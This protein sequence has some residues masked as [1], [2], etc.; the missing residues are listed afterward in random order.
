MKYLVM[1]PDYSPFLTNW[2]DYQNHYIEKMVIYNLINQT[3]S[4]DG[5]TWLEL[6]ID[7][8]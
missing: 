1:H 7:N 3:Y 5:I 8:L 2:F 6:S 4:R